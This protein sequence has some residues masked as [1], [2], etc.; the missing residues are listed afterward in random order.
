MLRRTQTLESPHPGINVSKI[1]VGGGVAGMLAAL[2]VVIIG[3]IG[4]P[5]TRWFL[6]ASLVVGV[7]IAL[8]RRWIG[9]A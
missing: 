9:R 2:S 1:P 8:L 7:F 5:V 6:A 3:L 4:L